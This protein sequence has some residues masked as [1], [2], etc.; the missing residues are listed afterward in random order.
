VEL[1]ASMFALVSGVANA[2]LTQSNERA[3]L[4]AIFLQAKPVGVGAAL[5]LEGQVQHV[6][7]HDATATGQE[8]PDSHGA[9][10]GCLK[11]CADKSGAVAKST[12]SQAETDNPFFVAAAHWRSAAPA[13]A[14]SRWWHFERPVSAGPPLFI[15]LLRLTI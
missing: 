5:P 14:A 6:L 9:E 12:A 15:R 13:I 4:G 7:H 3:G 1:V 8:G 10:E 11:V 2:C